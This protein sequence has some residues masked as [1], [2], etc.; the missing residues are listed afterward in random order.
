[1]EI[2]I[3]WVSIGILDCFQDIPTST[4]GRDFPTSRPL[5]GC[6]KMANFIKLTEKTSGRDKLCRVVQ[7]GSKFVY[8]V[9]EQGGVSQEL[10]A[11]LRA[12]EGS[13]STARKCKA[14]Q[15]TN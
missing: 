12:L 13:I 10:V 8:W 4:G 1:M 7:Y 6:V 14:S 2:T 15:H 5:Q 11:R 9:L 3:L